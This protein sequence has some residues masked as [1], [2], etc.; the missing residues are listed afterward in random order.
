MRPSTNDRLLVLWVSNLR[1]RCRGYR[2]RGNVHI[3]DD[4]FL[5]VGELTGPGAGSAVQLVLEH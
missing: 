5:G 2:A 4:A 1:G 3:E